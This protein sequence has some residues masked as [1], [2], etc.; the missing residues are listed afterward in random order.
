MY[1]KLIFLSLFTAGI[2]PLCAQH[3][4]LSYQASS[5]CKAPK[6]GP[7]GPTG[8]QGPTGD[9]GPRG[10]TGPTG[11]TGPQGQLALDSLSNVALTQAFPMALAD[12]DTIPFNGTPTVFGTAITQTAADTFTF[13]EDGNYYVH[14]NANVDLSTPTPLG[15]L[16]ILVNG[17]K[18]GTFTI[19][20]AGGPIDSGRIYEIEAGDILQIAALGAVT[21]SS[22]NPA[23]ISIIRLS[24][25]P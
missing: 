2:S 13:N 21:L 6:E 25:I 19:T 17:D 22:V 14:F 15:T 11:P 20:Q 7:T 10:P 4:D 9:R 18:F 1:Q 5:T 16:Q 24:D 12:A 8:P 3:L 23:S